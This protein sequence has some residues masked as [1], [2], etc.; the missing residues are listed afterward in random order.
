MVKN[1]IEVILNDSNIPSLD[2]EG[3]QIPLDIPRNKKFEAIDVYGNFYGYLVFL[4]PIYITEI[5]RRMI[6]HYGCLPSVLHF[7][8][9]TLES[10]EKGQLGCY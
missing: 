4:K 3:N 1:K 7:K 6:L 5:K 2:D 10:V 8:E 9:K